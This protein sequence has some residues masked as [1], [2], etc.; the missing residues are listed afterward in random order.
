[1]WTTGGGNNDAQWSNTDYDA[2][3]AQIKASSDPAERFKLMHQAEDIIFKENMLCP[4]Y[5]YVDLFL[6]NQK[7]QGFWSSPLGY[8]YFMYASV[9]N[10]AAAPD[11]AATDAPA[12]DATTPEADTTAPAADTTAPAAD[13]TTTE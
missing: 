3:I 5:Y 8:K 7:V 6:L 13:A 12:A 9:D 1:M 11:A 4:I 2:L 10:T